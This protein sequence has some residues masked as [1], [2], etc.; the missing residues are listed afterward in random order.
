MSYLQAVLKITKQEQINE[1][2]A[3]IQLVKKK[4]NLMTKSR[5]QSLEAVMEAI[6]AQTLHEISKS[7]NG[8]QFESSDEIRQAENNLTAIYKKV[9]AGESKLDEFKKAVIQWKEISLNNN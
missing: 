3:C 1:P 8:K 6:I 5:Q 7:C 4:V 9:I 2:A